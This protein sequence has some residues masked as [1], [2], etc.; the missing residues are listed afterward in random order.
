[1]VGGA[2]RLR[3]GRDS[4]SAELCSRALGLWERPRSWAG[5]GAAGQ[6][7]SESEEFHLSIDYMVVFMHQAREPIERRLQVYAGPAD[8]DPGLI[9]LGCPLS[10]T[11]I[12]EPNPEQKG[13]SFKAWK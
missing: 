2:L 13:F 3:R 6:R 1:M 4:L 10:E 12:S 8:S 7:A 11:L 5:L 9:D